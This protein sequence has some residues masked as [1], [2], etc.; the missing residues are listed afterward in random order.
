MAGYD[1]KEYVCKVLNTHTKEMYSQ[2]YGALR[3]YLDTFISKYGCV[4]VKG[5]PLNGK[6]MI[7]HYQL[8]LG[9]LGVLGITPTE[10]VTLPDHDLWELVMEGGDSVMSNYIYLV[11]DGKYTVYAGTPHPVLTTR[12]RAPSPPEGRTGEVVCTDTLEHCLALNELL[13]EVY[14]KGK[15]YASGLMTRALEHLE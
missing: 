4:V 2:P 15:R 5:G 11:T 9:V 8:P 7:S 6:C 12:D 1:V 10:E 3:Q 13:K 14:D